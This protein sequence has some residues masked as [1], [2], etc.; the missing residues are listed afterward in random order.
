MDP[1]IV[2]AGVVPS[3][4]PRRGP[5]GPL[6][7]ALVHEVGA[8]PVD[9]RT[10]GPSGNSAIDPERRR[11]WRKGGRGR[12]GGERQGLE[13]EWLLP[14]L[15]PCVQGHPLEGTS[16]RVHL[17]HRDP[18]LP[19]P[20]RQ[21]CAAAGVEADPSQV[22]PP[23]LLEPHLERIGE[24]GWRAVANQQ[25]SEGS[26]QLGP[27]DQQATVAGEV[28]PGSGA[29]SDHVG[30]PSVV[31]PAGPETA[32]GVED[33]L[34]DGQALGRAQD[35]LRAL[36]SQPL[37]RPPLPRLPAHLGDRPPPAD[38]GVSQ[39]SRHAGKR[40]QGGG[41]HRDGDEVSDPDAAHHPF[42]LAVPGPRGVGVDTCRG[43]CVSPL[44]AGDHQEL[45]T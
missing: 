15:L 27:G 21:G 26:G 7:W 23:R 20:I 44:V 14:D 33:D 29:A 4:A 39:E 31:E 28:E 10:D 6:L 22:T 32:V 42:L 17:L 37:R 8:D 40:Q 19:G 24:G 16:L 43:L 35:R 36:G 34:G 30:R 1:P 12:S 45:A 18:R 9:E 2:A 3:P 13:N 11:A 41:G 25:A 38:P 5:E